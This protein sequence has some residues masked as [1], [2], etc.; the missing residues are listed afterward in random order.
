MA[1]T[2]LNSAATGL[3]ALSTKIDVIANNLANAETTAFKSSR[4]NFEDLMYTMLRP[5]GTS[6]N[7]GDS[8]PAGTFVGLGVK[9]SNTQLDLSQGVMENTGRQLDVGIQGNGFFKVKILDTIDNGI[10]YTRNGNF[11]VNKDGYLVFGL[12]EGYNLIPPIQIPQGVTDITIGQ[13]GVVEVI[14]PNSNGQKQKVGDLKLTQFVNPQGL[15]LLGGSIY[16]ET[17]SSGPPLESK[18]GENGAGTL[19][20]GFL[21]G[22]NVDPV[23]EL[24]G[25]IKTQRAFELNS[26]SIQSADQALQVIGNLR[27]N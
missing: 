21:E 15:K 22:S 3:R 6:N 26:Q 17:E 14:K 27:R 4:M 25:L 7:A 23:K 16:T 2:A 19:L 18:P 1:I 11:F 12:G 8:S 9:I 20:Q 13:D 24:V 10:G 5:P